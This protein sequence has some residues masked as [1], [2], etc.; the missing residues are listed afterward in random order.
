MGRDQI[1]SGSIAFA[2]CCTLVGGD[3]SEAFRDREFLDVGGAFMCGGCLVV[4]LLCSKVRLPIAL[5][6]AFIMFD[7]TSGV[8]LRYRFLGSEFCLPAEKFL[9]PLSGVV[10]RRVG[11]ET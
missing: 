4:E 10:G 7:G 9:G 11:H 5:V 2:F 8:F 3:V 1:A 6:G